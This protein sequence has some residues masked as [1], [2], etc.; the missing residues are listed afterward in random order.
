LAHALA[1]LRMRHRG[2]DVV[3]RVDLLDRGGQE[4]LPDLLAQLR[5]DRPDLDQ[6]AGG[7]RA[8]QDEA[9]QA[10]SLA[11]ELA[12]R[13]DRVLAAH[14]AVVADHA[15]LAHAGRDP[16]GGAAGDRVEAEADG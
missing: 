1:A 10:L 4:A 9:D 3:D 5:V 11:D 12:A 16:R 2:P 13:H 8:P 14:R 6:R 15:A 7:Q